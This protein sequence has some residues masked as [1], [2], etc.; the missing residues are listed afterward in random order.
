MRRLPFAVF[1]AVLSLPTAVF[2]FAQGKEMG[3][4]ERSQVD[5]ALDQIS[6]DVVKHYYDP[7]L[8]GVAW[9]SKVQEAHQKIKDEKA[10][11]MAIAHVAAV[12]DSLNDSHTF[13]IPPRRPYVMDHGWMMQM[14]GDKAFVVR[15]RPG[16]DAD[17]H[18]VK[19]GDQLLAI[20]GYRVGRDNLWRIEYAFNVLRPLPQLTV[21]LR[22]AQGEDRKV[23]LEAKFTHI[24]GMGN[25]TDAFAGESPGRPAEYSFADTKIHVVEIGQD[26]AIIRLPSFMFDEGETNKVTSR[27]RKYKTVVFDPRQ[28][29]GGS[30]ETLKILVGSLFDHDVKISE[31]VAR[32][33]SKPLVAK[34][35]HHPFDGKVIV[36]IDSESASAAELMARVVQLEKRGT[37]IGDRSSGSVMEAK[38]YSYVVGTIA[39][40]AYGASITDANLIMADGKSLEH[41]GVT[42]D[43]LML[44]TAADLA[45]SRDPVLARAAEIA[46]VKLTPEEAWK[47]LPYDWPKEH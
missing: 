32:D 20:N 17:T 15:V 46:G 2:V 22:N 28:N 31:R 43:E 39:V 10:L 44:P 40:T 41:D 18:G 26:L 23:Q 4:E 34:G 37:V 7:K 16:G 33:N 9:D 38:H 27:M 5:S 25:L 19:P 1:W 13:L 6:K 42:P 3:Y 29:P 11:N 8:H 21:T 35:N 47:L 14:I 30:V 12:L 45:N 36:L 24:E